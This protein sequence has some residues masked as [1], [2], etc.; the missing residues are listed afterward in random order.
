MSALG[1]VL[2]DELTFCDKR[3][4]GNHAGN[5]QDAE[6]RPCAGRKTGGRKAFYL[7]EIEVYGNLLKARIHF[8]EEQTNKR[9]ADNKLQVTA[10]DSY[11]NRIYTICSWATV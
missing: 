8:R 10:K 1:S 4:N 3:K 2:S 11:H 9:N 6:K 7:S 5:L